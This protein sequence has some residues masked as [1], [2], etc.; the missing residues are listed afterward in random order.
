VAAPRDQR[1]APEIVAR[2]VGEDWSR[3]DLSGRSE[4]HTEYVRLDLAETTSS[5]G[6]LFE[7]CTFRDVGFDLAE[8]TAAAFLNC[9]FTGCQFIGTRLI[10]CKFLGSS[11]ERCSF[12]RM[13]VE[14]GDWSFVRLPGAGLRTA[15]FDDVRMR[16]ADLTGVDA[17]GGALRGCDLSAAT[18]GRAQLDRCDLRRSDLSALDPWNVGLR[19]AKINWEQ[20]VVLA[21]GFGLDVQPD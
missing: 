17:Q 19:G 4:S 10:G 7:S 11:F 9:T 18:L 3:D 15:T 21:V 1:A 20:A 6:L 12:E 16:E 8:H 5:G 14:G 2:V 13:T